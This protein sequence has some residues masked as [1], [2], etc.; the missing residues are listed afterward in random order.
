[1]STPRKFILLAVSLALVCAL[2]LLAGQAVLTQKQGNEQVRYLATSSTQTA[3]G[4]AAGRTTTNPESTT[5][6]NERRV[7][8]VGTGF[9]GCRV[10]ICGTGADNATI[11]FRVLLVRRGLSSDG[12]RE[13]VPSASKG[14]WS[15]EQYG[16]G[17]A[18]LST[19][20]GAATTGVPVLSTERIADTITWTVSTTA[21]TPT[22][23]G[24]LIEAS[25]GLGVSF[26]YSPADNTPAFLSIPDLDGAAGF[27]IEFDLGTA[28]SANAVV[29]PTP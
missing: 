26:V 2:G 20:V 25:N 23:P 10:H 11:A 29:E 13:W 1:M 14:D 12:A 19:A 3:F 28:T 4:L 6:A 7:V 24:A 16:A 18:T 21:T 27:V 5:A 15:L 17:S 8:W 22:G 9:R